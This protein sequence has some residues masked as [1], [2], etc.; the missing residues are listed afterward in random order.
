MST[1]ETMR[2]E[3]KSSID[4]TSMEEYDWMRWEG[5]LDEIQIIAPPP[6]EGLSERYNK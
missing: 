1:Q 4:I 2:L 6:W 5:I 3:D